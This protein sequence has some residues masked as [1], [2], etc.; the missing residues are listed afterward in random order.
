MSEVKGLWSFEGV[1]GGKKVN[2]WR[3]EGVH[4]FSR[5]CCRITE[6]NT[7]ALRKILEVVIDWVM[8]PNSCLPCDGTSMPIAM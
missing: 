1:E 8:G 2:D 3:V 4:T 7:A 5:I 6:C